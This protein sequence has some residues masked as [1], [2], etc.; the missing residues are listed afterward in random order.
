MKTSL[1]WDTYTYVIQ[2]MGSKEMYDTINTPLQS[3]IN[4]HSRQHNNFCSE[5]SVPVKMS[6]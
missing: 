2:K 5:I 6:I 3:Q 4:N 1:G